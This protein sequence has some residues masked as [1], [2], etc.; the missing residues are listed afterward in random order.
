MELGAFSIS[1]AVG[2]LYASRQF[3]EKFGFKAFV[4]TPHGTGR[5]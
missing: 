2:D 4:T 5:S 1:L 3:Y